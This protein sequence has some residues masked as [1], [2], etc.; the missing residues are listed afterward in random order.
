MTDATSTTTTAALA[1]GGVE[2]VER[3]GVPGMIYMLSDAAAPVMVSME[4]IREGPKRRQKKHGQEQA[5]KAKTCRAVMARWQAPST[6]GGRIIAIA[7]EGYIVHTA[8]RTKPMPHAATLLRNCV[9]WLC[10]L[11]TETS[12]ASSDDKPLLAIVGKPLQF[13]E[14]LLAALHLADTIDVCE[15]DPQH[16]EPPQAVLWMG[17]RGSGDVCSLADAGEWKHVVDFVQQGGGLL[18]AMCPWGFEQITG[19]D[20]ATSCAQNHVLRHFGLAF[21]AESLHSHGPL[22]VVAPH[23]AVP[24]D[25]RS[26]ESS[27]AGQRLRSL[28]DSAPVWMLADDAQ[29]ICSALGALPLDT[30]AATTTTT[31]TTSTTTTTAAP[32]GLAG[33]SPHPQRQHQQGGGSDARVGAEAVA[34]VRACERLAC[35]AMRSGDLVHAEQ[36]ALRTIATEKPEPEHFHLD[37]LGDGGGMMVARRIAVCLARTHHHHQQQQQ[38]IAGGGGDGDESASTAPKP[39]HGVPTPQPPPPSSSSSGVQT[40]LS[41]VKHVFAPSTTD[42]GDS[43]GRMHPK[44]GDLGSGGDDD[45]DDDNDDNDGSRG[46]DGAGVGAWLPGVSVFPNMGWTAERFVVDPAPQTLRIAS[47]HKEWVSTGLYLPPSTTMR[48]AVHGSTGKHGPLHLSHWQVRIGCHKDRLLHLQ[49][50]RRWPDISHT[51]ALHHG[52][53]GDGHDGDGAFVSTTFV[54]SAFGGLVYIEHTAAQSERIV[55]D[56]SHVVP[57]AHC[58]L[59]EMTCDDDLASWHERLNRSPWCELESEHCIFTVPSL[60]LTAR[61]SLNTYANISAVLAFWDQVLESHYDLVGTTPPRRKER[62]VADAQISAGYMHAGYPVMIQLDQVLRPIDKAPMLLDASNLQHKG[63]WGL[64]HEFGHHIQ[65][66]RWTFQGTGEVTVN[67]FTLYSMETVV[68]I[69]PWRHPW[70]QR[71]KQTAAKFLQAEEPAAAKFEQWKSQPCMALVTYARLQH[72]FGWDAFKRCLAAYDEGEGRHPHTEHDKI[73]T[74]VELMSLAVGCDLSL[75][76][77]AWGWPVAFGGEG[78]GGSAWR[79]RCSPLTPGDL[80]ALLTITT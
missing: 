57:S 21:G 23:L 54:T 67:F 42:G 31:A 72:A 38:P 66:P 32:F 20:V 30:I 53:G 33:S 59:D 1:R 80:T 27:H 61:P 26:V 60:A 19:A 24:P 25:C 52:G 37:L 43:A 16:G 63:S 65:D 46:G 5:K 10:H 47:E 12:R 2:K 79:Q 74:F 13:V 7:H 28:D 9:Q 11:D 68:H 75:Y 69:Q 8:K 18:V 76:F 73:N 35:D 50:W 77:A 78:D 70:L 41:A 36:A 55:L 15:W 64:F 44:S 29:H 58:C 14:R 22:T 4:P 34:F 51:Y 71:H 39:A 3:C 56:V 45:D 48:V 49:D 6:K 40:V 62:V 17:T